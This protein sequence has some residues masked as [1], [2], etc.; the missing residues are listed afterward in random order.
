MAGTHAAADAPAAGDLTAP[1]WPLG[2][3]R[4][5]IG[6]LWFQ[7]LLWKLPP[8]FGCG[9]ARDQGLCDWLGREIENP[10]IPLYAQFVQGIILPNLSILGWFIWLMEAAIAASLLFG[11]LTRLGGLLGF[12]QG[13]NLLIGLAAVPHE[14]YWTYLMLALLCLLFALTGAG[15]WLGVDRFLLPRVRGTL[16]ERLL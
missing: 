12:A 2:G 6:F 10:L 13:L 5:I 8:D 14:W 3:A 9:P 11:L 7:Q 1:G 4:I 16:L 15:R